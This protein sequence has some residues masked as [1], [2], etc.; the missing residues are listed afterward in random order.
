ME[1]SQPLQVEGI[2]A[3]K[4]G[5]R[6]IYDY[7]LTVGNGK[8]KATVRYRGEIKGELW[9]NLLEGKAQPEGAVKMVEAS[10]ENLVQMIE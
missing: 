9:G 10:I 8:W 4:Q 6:K 7:T 1:R 2:Y 3:R 5:M